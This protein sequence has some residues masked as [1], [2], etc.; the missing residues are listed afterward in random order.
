M[1]NLL[2]KAS[3]V[4]TPTAYGVGVLNSIKPAIPFGEELIVNGN[5]AT[6][7]DWTLGGGWTISGGTANA[8][9][10]TSNPMAQTVSGFAAGNIYKVRF[11][12]TA[13]T[14]GFIR[15]YAYVGASGTFT[16]IFNSPELTTGVYEGTFEFGGTNK[17]LRFYGSTGSAGGFAGSIDNVSVK[18]VTDADFD[19]T[20]NS[21]ATRVNPDYLIQDVSILSSNLVQNGN[22]SELG[23]Q[24]VTNGSFDTDSDWNLSSESIISN[25]KL[26][27]TN[28]APNSSIGTQSNVVPAQKPCKLQFDIVVNSGSFRILLG[29]GGTSTQINTSGT[30]TFYETSGNFGTIFLQARAGGFDGSIDN[31]SI[32]QV[33]PN[34]NWT[35]GTGW[36][37]GDGVAIHTGST[38]NLETNTSLSINKKY[39]V[40]FEI[41]TIADGVCNI[42]D[43]G[44]AT[45]YAS[46]TTTGIKS[47]IITKDSTGLLAIRSNS[48]NASIS[49]ISVIEV[50]QTDIPRL[51]YT[52]GTASIL[53]E[54]QRFNGITYS[55]NFDGT[56]MINSAII[57]EFNTTE[58]LSPE[59]INNSSKL[60]ANSDFQRYSFYPTIGDNVDV[61]VSV[62]AK[63]GSASVFKMLI[64]DK[65]GQAIND[66]FDLLNV[67]TLD[68]IG[69]I[70]NYGN[71]WYRCSITAS[72]SSGATAFQIRP[73]SHGAGYDNGW[74]GSNYIYGFGA[75]YE[76]GSYP[77]SYIPTSGSYVTRA[78]ETLN[79]AAN[80]DLIN[81]TEGVL[82]AEIAAL[83][84]D[85]TFRMLSISDGTNNN[86]VGIYFTSTSEQIQA[87]LVTGGVAQAVLSQTSA[88]VTSF[89]KIAISY[90]ENDVKL[91]INGI[92]IA[93]DT[94]A[95]VPTTGTFTTLQFDA[96]GGTSFF[97]GKC[98][99]VA[100]FSES[101]S[102]T[103]LACLT[104]TNNREI[105]LN[106]YYR[107]QYV[108]AN[109]EAV[110]CAQIKLNV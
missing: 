87:R 30:Y 5:F 101:L 49:N 12:V 29:S 91:Y 76:V 16:N 84:N 10:A 52:N 99:T 14:N 26:I 65:S 38:G 51:D 11:E 102:D 107:M 90:K 1:T 45:T 70:E 75:Q 37:F 50:Q 19:F 88:N 36:S 95:S 77:T 109:T 2:Y 39:K 27:V 67:T 40:Q 106:Y 32:K 23:S 93:S 58:T 7:S 108:G 20:R 68:G 92:L 17:T 80:S 24:L 9:S 71:G 62:F 35:L 66:T 105:F 53:L 3:I 89:N 31:V 21:S 57:T 48:T 8:V 34:D 44:S 85:G 42:Y 97:Y 72:T 54:P 46:F 4:T 74:T 79:N 104:S 55:N 86:R 18:E 100:V 13:V 60:T 56:N 6:D 78:A 41:L 94:S 83:D 82:Y 63:K 103:E 25:G 81:S 69:K 22:F 64:I 110:N 47:T 43:I 59:G 33:D 98:K 61:S 73:F 15:V 96:G 28:A